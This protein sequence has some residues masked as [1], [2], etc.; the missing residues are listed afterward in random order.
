MHLLV[1]EQMLAIDLW[2]AAQ[3]LHLSYLS[4][5]QQL[6][7]AADVMGNA[8]CGCR[9]MSSASQVRLCQVCEC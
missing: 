8:R 5:S 7:V 6:D 9:C 2:V 1:H 3:E 4:T